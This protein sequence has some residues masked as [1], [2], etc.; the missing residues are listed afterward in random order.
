[1]ADGVS[2]DLEFR[3]QVWQ[4]QLPLEIVLDDGDREYL[5]GSGKDF[6]IPS[7]FVT[8]HRWNY[9]SLVS[10]EIMGW[11]RELAS[12][13]RP[14]ADLPVLQADRLWY[15]TTSNN[16]QP[17]PLKWH[18]PLGLL[19]DLECARMRKVV[20]SSTNAQS[21]FQF[22]AGEA[23]E[24]IPMPWKL[25]L[26]LQRY[27]KEKL[28]DNPT[29]ESTHNLFMAQYKESEFL[30]HGSITR[31][32]NL[33]KKDQMQLWDSLIQPNYD[34]FWAVNE[35]VLGLSVLSPQTTSEK[36]LPGNGSPVLKHI[37]FRVYT[38]V[39]QDAVVQVPLT[40]PPEGRSTWTVGDA[41]R[42][43][44]D[45]RQFASGTA[46][47]TAVADSGVGDTP[48]VVITQGVTV[49]LSTPLLWLYRH[50]CYPDNFLHLLVL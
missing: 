22:T 16:A 31:V 8:T 1:M 49:D 21:P 4:G 15:T 36:P 44:L 20:K 41:I 19:Y 42:Y 37:P 23:L 39:A 40:L 33:A 14:A 2:L 38:V 6:F 12:S 24:P 10:V 25:T 11:L 7:Y 17:T 30:R 26:H 50:F 43:A 29:V 28:L 48:M 3:R 18:Y 35:H 45:P 32:M 13:H 27:P 46:P 34:R 9:L 47:P 5:L